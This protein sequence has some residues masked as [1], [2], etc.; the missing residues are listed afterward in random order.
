MRNLPLVSSY[1]ESF[2]KC[3]VKS[4]AKVTST[5]LYLFL[6]RPEE[7]V[8]PSS[9]FLPSLQFLLHPSIANHSRSLKVIIAHAVDD[10]DGWRCDLLWMRLVPSCK[11]WGSSKAL[12]HKIVHLML[13]NCRA[14]LF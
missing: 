4:K 6:R 14:N 2:A 5:T 10:V 8:L 12:A 3:Q 11:E 9:I 1:C 13:P 7:E